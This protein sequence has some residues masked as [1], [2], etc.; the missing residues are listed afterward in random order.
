MPRPTL[1]KHFASM[2]TYAV[3]L[4]KTTEEELKDHLFQAVERY[5]ERIQDELDEQ[6]RILNILAYENPY[7]RHNWRKGRPDRKYEK[8]HD[9][10]KIS[11]EKL[12][13]SYWI[14]NIERDFFTCTEHF[15]WTD[16]WV[17]DFRYK[18]ESKRDMYRENQREIIDQD[19]LTY[20]LARKE[21]METD[22]EWI[23]RENLHKAH[24]HHK[25]KSYYIELFKKD[26]GAER[27]YKGIIPD[28]ED[29]CEFCIHDRIVRE[30]REEKA[31]KEQEE[32]ER[33]IEES[34]LEYERQQKEKER[35]KQEQLQVERIEQVC[36]MCNYK[37]KDTAMFRLH[38]MS[39]EHQQRIKQKELYCKACDHQCRTI[40]EYEAHI[41]TNKHK[42]NA[43][44]V[45]TEPTTYEC[46]VCNFSSQFKHHYENHLKSK[47][48]QKACVQEVTL[49]T[50]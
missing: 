10:T 13:K 37:S 25:P 42:K 22:A 47:K 39:K 40:I 36:E 41:G 31:R 30:A 34:R 28:Y 2:R 11:E 50:T 9:V 38:M 24:L 26:K 20:Q 49:P 6:R 7:T 8:G 45:S 33:L 4:T 29:T 17:H 19:E 16:D 48:H 23:T 18:I 35:K 14:T 15:K 3:E 27:F 44:L 1:P 12:E 5:D 21:W 43:G 32:Y 46:H